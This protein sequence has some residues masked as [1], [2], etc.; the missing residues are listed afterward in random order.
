MRDHE[1][2]CFVRHLGVDSTEL[3]VFNLIDDPE[4]RLDALMADP[5][6]VFFIGG[7]GDYSVSQGGPEPLVAFVD[8]GIARLAAS[9]RAVFGSCWGY[10]ALAQGLGGKVERTGASELGTYTIR[11]CQG[12]DDPLITELPNEFLAQMG[13]KDWVTRLPEG[14]VALCFSES[15]PHH[16]VRFPGAGLVYGL[17]FHAELDREDNQARLLHYVDNYGGIEKARALLD[18][19]Q[20]SPHA[21]RLLARFV[22]VVDRAPTAAAQ[23]TANVTV[24]DE[25]PVVAPAPSA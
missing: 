4:H 25:R 18:S 21:N 7:S 12:V 19:F 5:A 14:S 13:H 11:K 15:S 3:E 1:V 23:A 6:S 22:E 9:G 16:A 10:H 24:D 8:Y 2:G 20:P 17:Q